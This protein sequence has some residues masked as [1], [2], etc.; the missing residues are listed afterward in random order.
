MQSESIGCLLIGETKRMRALRTKLYRHGIDTVSMLRGGDMLGAALDGLQMVRRRGNAAIVA[1]GELWAI[2]LALAAQLCV[3]KIVLIA[4]T[5]SVKRPENEKE[6][7]IDGLKRFAC[8]NLFFCVS[9]VLVL[10]EGEDSD[11]RIDQLCRGMCNSQIYRLS[12]ADQRWTNCELSPIDAAV[13][14][15]SEGE[16]TFSLAK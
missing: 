7:Q 9:D 2:A 12:M 1:E 11:K 5:D 8:R 15:L 16:F 13:R 3:E 4:P 6:K 10:E 14:F